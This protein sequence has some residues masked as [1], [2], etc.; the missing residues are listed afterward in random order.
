MRK[1]QAVGNRAETASFFLVAGFTISTNNALS[2]LTHVNALCIGTSIGRTT[3]LPY[4][5]RQARSISDA[6]TATDFEF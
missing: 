1:M 2:T 5:Q 4:T 6:A 3:T